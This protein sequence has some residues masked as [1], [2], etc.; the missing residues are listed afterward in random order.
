MVWIVVGLCFILVLIILLSSR[1]KIIL[2][3]TYDQDEGSNLIRVTIC[4]YHIQIYEK[5]INPLEFYPQSS[6]WRGWENKTLLQKMQYM[7]KGLKATLNQFSSHY[8]KVIPVLRK[9]QIKKLFW[10]TECGTG[11]ALTS[12]SMCGILWAAKGGV[13]RLLR[14][15][16]GTLKQ[17]HLQVTPHFQREVLTS[18]MHCIASFTI[19]KAILAFIHFRS[20]K[21]I[22]STERKDDDG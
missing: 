16:T 13:L 15:K 18:K 21:N 5:A 12:G 22:G 3:Y 8:K 17:V 4:L 2:H 19:G 11:D 20:G 14:Q 6:I 1:L 10:E 7:P 9:L